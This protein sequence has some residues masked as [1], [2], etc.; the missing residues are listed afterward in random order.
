MLTEWYIK[1]CA[2]RY[3]SVI[4]INGLMFLSYQDRILLFLLVSW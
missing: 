1:L 4:I 3:M 2:W